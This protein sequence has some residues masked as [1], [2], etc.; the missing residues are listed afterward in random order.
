MHECSL[1]FGPAVLS[2]SHAPPPSS[3]G[4]YPSAHLKQHCRSEGAV[5]IESKTWWHLAYQQ[6]ALLPHIT[7]VFSAVTIWQ[8]LPPSTTALQT[9]CS[10]YNSIT[11]HNKKN[12]WSLSRQQR[13]RQ[14]PA[15][16]KEGT[17]FR[18]PTPLPSAVSS[19]LV[20]LLMC[21]RVLPRPFQ[22]F[23]SKDSLSF[24]TAAAS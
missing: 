7:R 22:V 21:S 2:M 17:R 23:S 19:W 4:C 13:K 6:R 14:P 12:T 5:C 8:S 1:P 9:R 3:F 10:M 20:C 11:W 15:W 18:I 16:F 24:T